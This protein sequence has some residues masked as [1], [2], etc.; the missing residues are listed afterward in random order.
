[1]SLDQLAF[2]IGQLSEKELEGLELAF[3]P[4]ERKEI[5]RRRKTVRGLARR[6][7]TLALG[8]LQAEF[9]SA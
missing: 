6:G 9:T 1:M 7:K 5:L 3:K 8:D 2:T 4:R